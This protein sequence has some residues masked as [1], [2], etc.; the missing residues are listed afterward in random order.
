MKA[1]REIRNAISI[2]KVSGNWVVSYPADVNNLD[3]FSRAYYTR[4]KV[5][6]QAIGYNA[7]AKARSFAKLK[8]EESSNE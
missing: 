5:F 3:P 7:Y 4:E 8:A 2:K 1:Y 6:S